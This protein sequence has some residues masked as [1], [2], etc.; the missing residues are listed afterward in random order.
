MTRSS[1]I[2]GSRDFKSTSDLFDELL[3]SK[4][5]YPDYPIYR[6]KEDLESVRQSDSPLV[7]VELP[8]Q[9]MTFYVSREKVLSG[10]IDPTVMSADELFE[11]AGV[12]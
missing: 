7:A 1:E 10:E 2:E 4:P 9:E 3:R 12:L 5:D 11:H 8:D 6:G